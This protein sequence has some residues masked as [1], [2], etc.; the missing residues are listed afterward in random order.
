VTRGRLRAAPAALAVV[1][2]AVA[3]RA[4]W[5]EPRHVRI[6]RRRLEL[7]LWPAELAGMRVAV[8]ADL[9]TGVAHVDAGTVARVVARVNRERPDL[10]ALLGDYAD[11]AGLGAEFV[12]PETVAERL[13]ELRSQLGSVAVLGNHDWVRHGR[14]MPAALRDAGVTVLE[15]EVLALARGAH[16]FWIA[17]LAD[18]LTRTPA[19][20]RTLAGVPDGEPVLVL[21]HNPDLFPLVPER[22]TLTLA[23][24]THGGQVDLPLVRRLAVGSR[25]GARHASGH[26]EEE[27]R[28]LFVTRGVGTSRLAVRLLARPEVALL[29]LQA[30]RR[31]AISRARRAPARAARRTQQ[32]RTLAVDAETRYE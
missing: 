10:V 12:A 20:A 28:H 32:V 26:F 23:G 17:G 31:I 24:H 5:W 18:A 30:P 16:R 14:R 15:N 4:L 3:F 2:G 1:L 27:G 11:P 19:V 29:E 25:F 7:P 22:V 8:I 13:G 6:V 9:H 21:S